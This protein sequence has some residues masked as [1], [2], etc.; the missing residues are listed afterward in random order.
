M[1]QVYDKAY[2]KAKDEE[3]G[4]SDSGS[5]LMHSSEVEQLRYA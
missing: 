5:T 1:E 4:P 2:F 3:R